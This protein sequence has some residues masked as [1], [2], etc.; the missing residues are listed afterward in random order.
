MTGYIIIAII[1]LVLSAVAAPKIFQARRRRE[2]LAR[3]LTPG[4]R[5]MLD[6]KVPLYRRIPEDLKGQLDGLI[7]IFL[8]EKTFFGCGGL[9]VTDE[10][11]L[12]IAAQACI[13]LL[14]RTTGIY[15]RLNTIYIYPQSYVVD[16]KHHEGFLVIEGKDVR[17]GESWQNGPVVLAWDSIANAAKN[18]EHGHNVVLHEFAHQLDQE[19]GEVNGVPMLDSL[20]SFETWSEVMENEYE[21]LRDIVS[22]HD[23]AVLDS[24]GATDPAEFF[25]VATEAF[26]ENSWQMQSWCPRLYDEFEKY[27]KLDPASWK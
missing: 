19:D 16:A 10:I 1:I 9:E 27:Y 24:Y 12:I 22:T 4:Q 2:L 20:S 8:S 3:P 21:K 14:N 25:A 18:S 26:F 7:Q 15:P 6:E 5:F 17:V 23:H 13:L 11:K